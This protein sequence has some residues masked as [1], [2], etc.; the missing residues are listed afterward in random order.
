MR[1]HR[2]VFLILL[3]SFSCAAGHAE[4]KIKANITSADCL[5]F[6]ALKLESGK[7]SMRLISSAGDLHYFYIEDTSDTAEGTEIRRNSRFTDDIETL[8]EVKDLLGGRMH[9]RTPGSPYCV[10]YQQ[11]FKRANL[12]VVTKKASGDAVGSYAI[13]VGPEEHFYI[14]ADMPITNVKQLTYDD[15]S[16]EVIEK[17]KPGAFYI[18]VNGRWG[19][20][21]TE[22]NGKEWYKNLS[23][24]GLFKASKKP[25]ESIG[26]GIGYN[27]E[28]FELFIAQIWTKDD[29]DISGLKIGATDATVVGI[30]FNLSRGAEWL[31]GD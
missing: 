7:S 29:E 3:A 9:M 20:L 1:L 30:S 19:D 18:G 26:I 24:K 8:K 27:F 10:R 17:E 12:E 21:Y 31:K 25:G 13:V 14:T 28:V 11:H 23:I 6:S 15:K 16:G 2:H 4:Q 22:Y 5:P